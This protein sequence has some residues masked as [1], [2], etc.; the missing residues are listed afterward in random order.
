M[1]TYA[2]MLH[3]LQTAETLERF[4]T[5]YG[6][7]D[8]MLQRQLSRYSQAVKAHMELFD[9]PESLYLISAPGRTEIAGNHTDHQNGRVLAAAVN[10]DMVAAVTPR[11]S[12]ACS[13]SAQNA[14][15]A[16]STP[17][18][19][20]L[21]SGRGVGRTVRFTPGSCSVEAEG[22]RLMLTT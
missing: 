20:G 9:S 18:H 8:G 1:N 5:L 14:S 2:R 6:S 19:Q 10:L 21:P 15:G 12:I 17:Q 22:R 13:S 11:L 4:R 3:S 7:R 16:K